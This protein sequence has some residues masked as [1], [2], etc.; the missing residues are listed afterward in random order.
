MGIIRSLARPATATGENELAVPKILA[1]CI[2]AAR[3]YVDRANS[4]YEAVALERNVA[5][6]MDDIL[7]YTNLT[8][9]Q[10]RDIGMAIRDV[11]DATRALVAVIRVPP[12]LNAHHDEKAEIARGDVRKKLGHL[13]RLLGGVE[14]NDFAKAINAEHG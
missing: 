4:S 1:D 8:A 2:A 9:E 10:M 5:G 13:D 7:G 11:N 6:E 12:A 14:V 3:R